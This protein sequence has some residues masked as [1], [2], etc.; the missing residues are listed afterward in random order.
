MRHPTL[1][2][3][4]RVQHPNP[5]FPSAVIARLY[6]A[7]RICPDRLV[8]LG[9][10]YSVSLIAPP[11]PYNG[12]DEHC[13]LRAV[14]DWGGA[15]LGDPVRCSDLTQ[16]SEQARQWGCAVAPVPAEPLRIPKPRPSWWARRLQNALQRVPGCAEWT[17][18]DQRGNHDWDLDI[19]PHGSPSSALPVRLHLYGQGGPG[20]PERKYEARVSCDWADMRCAEARTPV[21]DQEEI[22]RDN[23]GEIQYHLD[24]YGFLRAFCREKGIPFHRDGAYSRAVATRYLSGPDR[25]SAIVRLVCDFASL[26]S[27][28]VTAW[29]NGPGQRGRVLEESTRRMWYPDGMARLMASS[30]DHA[31]RDDHVLCG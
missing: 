23:K 21:F 13:L 1:F 26:W 30:V 14:S 10:P 12:S 5:Y 16:A 20:E 15:I 6:V 4:I 27:R 2:Y 22:Q 17:V 11:R 7:P 8:S 9:E 25:V 3:C 29:I 28:D 19:L 18:T 31:T 24:S